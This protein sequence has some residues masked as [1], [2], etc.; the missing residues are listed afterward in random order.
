M[1]NISIR[2]NNSKSRMAIM[3]QKVDKNKPACQ[4]T[5][6]QKIEIKR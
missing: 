5:R 3:V 1:E 2:E 6:G 4:T